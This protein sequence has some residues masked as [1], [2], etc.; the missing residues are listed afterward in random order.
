MDVVT[1]LIEQK[2]AFQKACQRPP[3]QQV[4]QQLHPKVG[5]EKGN[6]KLELKRCV[7]EE[8]RDGGCQQDSNQG[9]GFTQ[10]CLWLKQTGR[11][12]KHQVKGKTDERAQQCNTPEHAPTGVKA[13]VVQA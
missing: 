5:I 7:K 10:K 9:E 13:M 8:A 1:E 12:G 2:G 11:G 6:R 4:A 3:E